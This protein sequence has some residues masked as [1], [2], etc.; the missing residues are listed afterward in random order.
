MD[1]DL[2]Q[3]CKILPAIMLR[4]G[5]ALTGEMKSLAKVPFSKTQYG[6]LYYAVI[7]E[8][9]PAYQTMFPKCFENLEINHRFFWQNFLRQ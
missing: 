5:K 1:R 7:R 4:C 3:F 2:K 6:K 9:H 8:K